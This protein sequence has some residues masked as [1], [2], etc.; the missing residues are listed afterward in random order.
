VAA[1]VAPASSS[2]FRALRP[3]CL[4]SRRRR[5]GVVIH[6]RIIATGRAGHRTNRTRCASDAV[7][8]EASLLAQMNR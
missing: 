3:P 4:V 8:S 7:Y 2:Q 6:D 1:A 5:F